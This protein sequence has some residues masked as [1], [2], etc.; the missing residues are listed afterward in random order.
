MIKL[1][2]GMLVAVLFCGCSDSRDELLQELISDSPVKRAGALRILAQEGDEEAYLL[3]SQALEDQSAV[4]RIAAVRALAEFKGRDTTAALVR[5]SRDADPEV[6]EAVVTAL[7][8]RKG[9]AMQRALQHML[10]RAERSPQVREQI[11]LA[12]EKSGLSGQRLAEE[13][14]S[15][16]MEMIRQEW[17]SSRGSRRAQL[18]RLAGRSVHPDAVGVVMEGLADKNADVV[19]AALSVLDGRGGKPALRQLLLLASDQ[20]VRVRL[21]AARALRN[22]GQ[23][24]VAVLGGVLRDLNPD[25]R[26]QALVQLEKVEQDLDPALICPLLGDKEEAVLLQTAS[27]IRSKKLGCDLAPLAKQLSDPADR[28]YKS[29]VRA[30]SIVGGE[31][32]LKLLNGQMQKQPAPVRPILAAAMAHAGDRDKKTKGILEKELRQVLSDIKLRADAWV[33]GKLPPTRKPEEAPADH[34]RLSEEELKKLYEKHGLP[35]ASKDSPRGISDILAKYEKPSGRA[36]AAEMFPAVDP[37]DV[38]LFGE[39]LQG[40]A[41]IDK[42]SAAVVALEALQLEYQELVGRVAQ[43]VLDYEL[44]VSPDEKM[45]DRLGKLMLQAGEQDAGAIAGLLGAT[46]RPKA[47]EVLGSALSGM[48]WEKREHAIAALGAM[49]LKEGIQP[50]LPML[51]GYSAASAARALGQIGDP[52]AIGPLQ[53]A[54]KR[55][56]PSAEMDIFLALSKLGSQDVVAMVSE[57]LSDPDPEVR[58]A[59]VRILGT[60]GDAEARKALETVQFDLDR[61]VRAEASNFLKQ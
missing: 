15:Q 14:A 20:S 16:Q 17:Q 6:R 61:L 2:A 32:A 56:G 1:T 60:L 43:L 13:M 42:M 36:P 50:L 26:L 10:L 37:Q 59:A 55:A 4:V 54:L 45:I 46:K 33:T 9:E 49:N 24:G 19:L 30:L 53:E 38:E 3:V 8:A 47:V 7:S 57:R 27:L 48:P 5:A 12:L 40:L 11:Y 22:Y 21:Q 44:A 34:S 52:E 18:V 41:V 39:L 51:E 29:A 35:P 31:P 58:R 25:V 28:S 23:E